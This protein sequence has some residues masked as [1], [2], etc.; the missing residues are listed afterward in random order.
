MVGPAS[1]LTELTTGYVG[2][3]YAMIMIKAV[4][5]MLRMEVLTSA[6][7]SEISLGKHILT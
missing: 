4:N 6:L 1:T 3:R 5:R 2:N 7:R